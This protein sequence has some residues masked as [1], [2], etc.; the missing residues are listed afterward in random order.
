MTL[1]HTSRPKSFDPKVRVKFE[2]DGYDLVLNLAYFKPNANYLAKTARCYKLIGFPI[3]L[4][5]YSG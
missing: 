4:L 5:Y 2:V 3:L 1:G